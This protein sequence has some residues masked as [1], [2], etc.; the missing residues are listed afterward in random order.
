[1]DFNIVRQKLKKAASKEVIALFLC[2]EATQDLMPYPLELSRA[3][4]R[5]LRPRK[6][7]STAYIKQNSN[8]YAEITFNKGYTDER[9]MRI[10]LN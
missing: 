7:W 1:M 4:K 5:I 10:K 3:V 9:K 8:L 2:G 6:C